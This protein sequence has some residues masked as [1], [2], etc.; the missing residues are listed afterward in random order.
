MSNR[1]KKS[2]YESN[3]ARSAKAIMC[4]GYPTLEVLNINGSNHITYKEALNQYM[5]ANFAENGEWIKKG[6]IYDRPIPD[7]N[8]LR[9]KYSSLN[10][11]TLEKF[12]LSAMTQHLNKA[13]EDKRCLMVQCSILEQTITPYGLD[14]CRRDA[15]FNKAQDANNPLDMLESIMRIHC[16]TTFSSSKEGNL[17][18]CINSYYNYQVKDGISINNALLEFKS[19]IENVKN[20][21]VNAVPSEEDQVRQFTRALKFSNDYKDF[22]K[23][24]NEDEARGIVFPKTL[25]EV[26]TS[27]EQFRRINREFGSRNFRFNNQPLVYAMNESKNNNNHNKHNNHRNKSSITCFKCQKLGHFAWECKSNDENNEGKDDDDSSIGSGNHAQTQLQ[28]PSTPT[29]SNRSNSSTPLSNNQKKKLKKKQKKLLMKQHNTRSTT[30]NNVSF[31][32][33]DSFDESKD[34]NSLGFPVLEDST[35][36]LSLTP[37]NNRTVIIDSGATC[38]FVNNKEIS[39][40]CWN[41]NKI[42]NGINGRSPVEEAVWI[43]LIGEALFLPNSKV[44]GFSLTQLEKIGCVQYNQGRNYTI[45]HDNDVIM[46]FEYN[47][48]NSL[49]I[50]TLTDDMLNK[51]REIEYKKYNKIDN[52][53][54]MRTVRFNEA[55]YTKYEVKKAQDARVAKRRTGYTSDHDLAKLS[56]DGI[57]GDMGFTSRDVIR[58]RD[59][60]GIDTATLAGKSVNRGPIASR[61]EYLNTKI[62]KDQTVHADIFTWKSREFLLFVSKPLHLLLCQFITKN[63]DASCIEEASKKLINYLT[64]KG[65][66]ILKFVADPAKIFVKQEVISRSVWDIGGAG[67]HSE[68]VEREIRFVKDKLRCLDSDIPYVIPGNL[69]QYSVYWTIFTINATRRTP[70]GTP[71]ELYNGTKTNYKRDMKLS[72]G[73]YGHSYIVPKRS[74]TNELRTV[75]SIALCPTGNSK[76]T[77]FC[78]DYEINTIF[79]SDR[80]TT[81]PMPDNV[82]FKLNNLAAISNVKFDE[83]S[84]PSNGTEEQDKLNELENVFKKNERFIPSYEN[85]NDPFNSN[86]ENSTLDGPTQN[87]GQSINDDDHGDNNDNVND[88]DNTN[89]DIKVPTTDEVMKKM[90]SYMDQHGRRKSGRLE[91]LGELIYTNMSIADATSKHGRPAFEAIEKEVRNLIERRT[92]KF[93]SAENAKGKDFIPS[94]MF[95]K[96]KYHPDGTF[97]KIKARLVAGG[98]HQDKELYDDLSA[99]T[100]SIEGIMILLSI[101]AG[102]GLSVA[103]ADIGCAFLEARMDDNAN[104]VYMKISGQVSKFMLKLFPKLSKY[105][106]GN[107][108][109]TQLLGALYGCVEAPIL[110]YQLLSS[111]LCEFGLT[112][113]SVDRCIFSGNIN[114][115]IMMTAIHVDDLLV[116][117]NDNNLELFKE[118][119]ITKF[120]EVKWNNER[121]LMYLS[122]VIS[123]ENDRITVS[124]PEYIKK[125]IEGVNNLQLS[126][127]PH[128]SDLYVED[129]SSELLPNSEKEE[130]H[131]CVAKL[132]YLSKRCRPDVLLVVSHLAGRVSKPTRKDKDALLKLLGYLKFTIDLKLS[133]FRGNVNP[134]IYADA[135][136]GCHP[137]GSSRSGIVIMMSGGT[138]AAY[139]SKQKMITLSSCESELISLTEATCHGIWI[140]NL[141]ISLGFK[142]GAIPICEDN[143]AAISLVSNTGTAKRRRTRHINVKYEFVKQRIKL[144]D[145]KVNYVSTDNMIADALTKPVTLGIFVKLRD[146]MLG[147]MGN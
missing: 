131:S 63:A 68:H 50:C 60:Y 36:I 5:K 8:E 136:F 84:I 144:G 23:R 92:F 102:K 125:C 129:V 18:E 69:I 53:Y 88:I 122:M 61:E 145:V 3:K 31:A 76:G 87:R 7:E 58:A 72:F 66:N 94:H 12:I 139:T 107:C 138:V 142:I 109:Y 78:Y 56:S 11:N 123:I 28:G 49:Y 9:L 59:I 2:N 48:Y 147:I 35:V 96:E 114:G 10:G 15:A 52:I 97:D 140:K 143:M 105:V 99:P 128:S 119:L 37:F 26:V 134:T 85:E 42:V 34:D 25:D 20:L 91:Q 51:L 44:S 45:T 86:S 82:I 22:V 65:F 70:L 112:P 33:A 32:D 4:R 40:Y 77:W 113:S 79:R 14:I 133:Y 6:K 95:I 120:K 104:P 146:M 38:S 137:D 24:L 64:Q 80:F 19:R 54:M 116:T 27:A 17:N 75:A 98:N 71:R 127:V 21:S 130:F 101:A 115:S 47:K 67:I 93:I 74:N 29:A 118:F 1:N 57:L 55:L 110:W 100:A 108:L 111:A 62:E 117:G 46:I 106:H 43:P 81:L 90:G 30:A 135:S 132:V 16:G 73:E 126:K 39:D 121:Q 141:L 124:M 13:Q 41:I 83:E 89:D 103:T